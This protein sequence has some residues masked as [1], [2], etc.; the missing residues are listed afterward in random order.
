MIVL[1]ALG[2]HAYDNDELVGTAMHSL[3]SRAEQVNNGL[4]DFLDDTT[5]AKGAPK[6]TTTTKAPNPF[7]AL[8]GGGSKGKGKTVAKGKGKTVA[9]GRGKTKVRALPIEDFGIS[10]PLTPS[11][12]FGPMVG[13]MVSPVQVGPM[14]M[15]PMHQMPISIR[16]PR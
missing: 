1:L 2:A 8:F 15:K 7:A 4:S 13:P 16:V 9:K 11:S 3:A 10:R 6:T 12:Q 14:P 5:M